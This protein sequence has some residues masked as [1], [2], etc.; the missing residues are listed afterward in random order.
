MTPELKKQ[1]QT[2]LS[3][4]PYLFISYKG[5]ASRYPVTPTRG[6]TAP[7]LQLTWGNAKQLNISISLRI[8][9]HYETIP[10]YSSCHY[11]KLQH[12][13]INWFS[14]PLLQLTST[15]ST[16]PIIINLSL[17]YLREICFNTPV[18]AEKLVQW[19][20]SNQSYMC[21]HRARTNYV[22]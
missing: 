15:K 16:S 8:P 3:G 14:T 4:K 6:M 19:V 9:I 10:V 21:S 2:T 17:E 13:R 7:L 5:C 22:P 11:N 18:P 1:Q 20:S 12:V